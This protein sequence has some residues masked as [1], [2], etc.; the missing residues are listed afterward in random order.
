MWIDYA[1]WE[2]ARGGT[3]AGRLQVLPE[4]HSPQLG[5]RGHLVAC[6]PASHG[7]PERRYPVIYMHDGQNLFDDATSF[8]GSWRVGS[9]MDRLG[10]EGIEAIVIGIPNAGRRRMEEYG[11]FRDRR[12]GGG[13]GDDYLA[14]LADTVK[15]LVDRSF[16]TLPEPRAT[17]I[18]GSSMGGLISLYGAFAR[19]DAFGMAAALSPSLKFSGDAIFRFVEHSAGRPRRLYLD[20]GTQEASHLPRSRLA[21][22]MRSRR[23]AARVRRM[24]DLLLRRGFRAG[25]DLLY[26]EEVGAT[27][28]EA[29]W[30]RR[31]PEAIRFLLRDLGGAG[32]EAGRCR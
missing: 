19:P 17:V 24:R 13:R 32:D 1:E 7:E 29:A 8:A 12:H 21:R 5:R 16:R 6:L 30:A 9:T 4:L 20:V 10:G 14:F 27:H 2:G 18:A 26:V 3:P 31:L 15:P 11:P 25:E 22:L 28:N 23:Y